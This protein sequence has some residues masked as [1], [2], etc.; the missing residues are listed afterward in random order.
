MNKFATEN[1]ISCNILVYDTDA[2]ALALIKSV[3][4][5]CNI[6]KPEVETGGILGLLQKASS[7][8]TDICAVFL[9]EAE[10]EQGLTGFEIAKLIRGHRSNIPIFMRLRDQRGRHDL[11]QAERQLITGGYTAL[12]PEILRAHADRFLY[13]RYFPNALVDLFVQAGA[14][15]LAA[16]FRGCE[17]RVSKPFL[18]YDHVITTEYTAILPVQFNYGSGYI[19]F[20]I[21]ESDARVL[22]ANE[23]T[24]LTKLQTDNHYINQLISEVMNLY[25]GKVRQLSDAKFKQTEPKPPVSIPIVVS[26]KKEYISFGNKIPQLC[27]RYLLLREA[28]MPEPCLVEFKVSFLNA[29]DPRDFVAS[30]PLAD[31]GPEEGSVEIF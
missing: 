12:E 28:P 19:T 2:A 30:D 26:H 20:L 5:A 23:H 13:G 18:A 15:V 9:C 24:A 22:I 1:R 6:I 4:S 21:K 3:V 8:E 25:W 31:A 14:D 7:C 16:L 29:L 10:D 27:F 11:N 17:I